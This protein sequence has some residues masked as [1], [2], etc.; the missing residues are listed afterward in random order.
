MQA[1]TNNPP[2]LDSGQ[3][4]GECVF[5]ALDSVLRA[6]ISQSNS[7]SQCNQ[8]GWSIQKETAHLLDRVKSSQYLQSSGF[9]HAYSIENLFCFLSSGFVGLAIAL[10]T[11]TPGGRR[12]GLLYRETFR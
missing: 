1:D 10:A 9:T 5:Q 6:S 8:Y 12:D 3:F 7:Q 11:A 4:I 2:S